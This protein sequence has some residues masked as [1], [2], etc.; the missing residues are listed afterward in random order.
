MTEQAEQAIVVKLLQRFEP[1][2]PKN[3]E[4]RAALR[5]GRLPTELALCLTL[6]RGKDAVDDAQ[7]S[8]ADALKALGPE[9][10]SVSVQSRWRIASWC[11][12]TIGG[13]TP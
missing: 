5:A 3:I 12:P 1:L 7:Q 9:V 6:G 4:A 2:D 8:F 11:R 10:T 13:V